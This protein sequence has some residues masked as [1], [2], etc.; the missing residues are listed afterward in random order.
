MQNNTG[1]LKQRKLA[2]MTQKELAEKSCVNIRQ[3]QK[4]E[5]GESDIGC[6][7]LK[8]AIALANALECTVEELF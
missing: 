5:N 4:Y 3:I 2:N 1:L 7:T 6:M 8:N